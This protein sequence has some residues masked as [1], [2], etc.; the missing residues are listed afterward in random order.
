M[1]RLNYMT[2]KDEKVGERLSR[3]MGKVSS[4]SGF[5]GDQRVLVLLDHK[6]D[7]ILFEGCDYKISFQSADHKLLEYLQDEAP[8]MFYCSFSDLQE[9][10]KRILW[11]Y[12]K[13]YADRDLEVG[14]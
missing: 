5:N 7:F 9:T 12:E 13:T 1:N 2:I 4:Y 8:N 11:G 6:D 3:Y 10:V 14:F